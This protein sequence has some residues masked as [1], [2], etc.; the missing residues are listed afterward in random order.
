MIPEIIGRLPVITYT[1]T[2]DKEALVKILT[3]PKNAIIKQYVKLLEMDGIK[4]TFDNEVLDYIADKAIKN[5]IGAR[6]LRGI[7]ED[8][9]SNAMFTL[10]TSGESEFN[11]TIDYAKE[12]LEEVA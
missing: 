10:P 11:V 5:K 9:M 4:L 12:K 3:E 1:E 8:L 7:V 6:A 2:L